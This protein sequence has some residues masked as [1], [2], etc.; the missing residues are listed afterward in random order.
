MKLWAIALI[1][2]VVAISLSMYMY[3]S[4]KF[5]SYSAHESFQ[6]PSY[7]NDGGWKDIVF[8]ENYSVIKEGIND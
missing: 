1:V 5:V 2:S 8:N 7:M 3:F 4:P 6:G